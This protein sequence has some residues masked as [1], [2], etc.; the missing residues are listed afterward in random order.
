MLCLPSKIESSR[1]SEK[2]EVNGNIVVFT[3]Q[4][5]EQSQP[6]KF[7]ADVKAGCVYPP[8]SRAVATYK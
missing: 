4:N 1:N 2:L 7:I 3:L 8:K 6:E 5:R